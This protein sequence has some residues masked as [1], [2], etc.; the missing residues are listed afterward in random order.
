MWTLLKMFHSGD[1]TSFACHSD[2]WLS[3]FLTKKHT[4]SFWHNYKW[5]SIRTASWNWQLSILEQ[6]WLSWVLHLI[7]LCWLIDQMIM[8]SVHV[9]SSWPNCKCGAMLC[10]SS[11]VWRQIKSILSYLM[12]TK[13]VYLS[14]RM[15]QSQSCMHTIYIFVVTPAQT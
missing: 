3:S 8:T 5:H 10:M 7:A 13:G 4:S 1:M 9:L 12:S 14:K 2:R 15:V 11:I 6:L